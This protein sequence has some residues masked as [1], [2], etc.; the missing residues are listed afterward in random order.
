MMHEEEAAT[1]V[2]AALLGDGDD[3]DQVM[4]EGGP[5]VQ[6]QRIKCEPR[7]ARFVLPRQRVYTHQYSHVYLKRLNIMRKAVTEQCL[8]TWG[9]DQKIIDRVIELNPATPTC[10]AVGTLFKQQPLKPS[11]LSEFSE[12]FSGAGARQELDNFCSDDDTMVLEDESGRMELD[13]LD[14]NVIDSL[15][16]GVV[17]AVKGKLQETGQFLVQELLF[18]GLAPQKPLRSAPASKPKYVLFASGFMLGDGNDNL[19]RQMLIDYVLG[20]L[21]S[22]KDQ[23]LEAEI[24]RVV[25]AGGSV[26]AAV[27]SPTGDENTKKSNKAPHHATQ[28][29]KQL[30]YSLAELST[31]VDVDVMPGGTDPCNLTMPQQP[32]HRCLFPHSE[33]FKDTFH[34]VTN[35]YECELGDE[36]AVLL[37]SA[38]QPIN[39]MLKHT[40]NLT[41]LELLVSTLRYR[42]IAP[43]APDSLPCYPLTETDPF[44]L[45]E[46]PHVYFCGDQ[47]VFGTQLV[48]GENGVICRA[49]AIPKFSSTGQV[50]LVDIA[51]PNLECSTLKF[52]GFFP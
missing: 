21:G 9:K 44:V 28:S 26:S 23:T 42:H 8:S 46:T 34:R 6:R 51:S 22:G 1:A 7:F 13:G 31:S 15:V 33:R 14:L 48:K 27:A 25:V 16:T 49:V 45:T 12:E 19:R 5:A 10:V 50:V 11:V 35:P 4:G 36:G 52:D 40:R 29:V 20:Q 47:D 32:L 24:V 30:D 43:T 37:G 3:G 17:V 38:G 41:A 2:P 18:P 39:D